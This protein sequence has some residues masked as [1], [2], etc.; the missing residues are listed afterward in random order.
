M[1]DYAGFFKPFPKGESVAE[2]ISAAE[3]CLDGFTACFNAGDA[4]GMDAHLHFPHVMFSGAEQLVWEQPGQ[5]P[6]DFFD[7]LR[8]TG[9][10]KTVY[11]EKQPIYVSPDKVHFRVRYTR[12][13]LDGHVLTEHENIWFVTR[14]A[15]R[16]GIALRSY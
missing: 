8:K 11:E 2:L 5:L 14:I 9:W 10:A 12:R 3:A 4:A 1:S 13:A 16:W 7:E 6:V 15:G